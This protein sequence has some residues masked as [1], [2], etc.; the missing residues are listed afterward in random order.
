M[1]YLLLSFVFSLVLRREW[2]AWAAVFLLFTAAFAAPFLGPS[3]AANVVT[4]LLAGIIPA[5]SVLAVARFGLLAFAGSCVCELL[6]V[7]P[8]TTDLSAW[9]AYQGVAVALFVTG[10]DVYAVLIA[11][12]GQR[13]FREWFFNEV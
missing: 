12:R 13:L 9:Y 11:T 10:L 6:S 1:M 4:L 7:A 8:P 3:R 5:V 2:L